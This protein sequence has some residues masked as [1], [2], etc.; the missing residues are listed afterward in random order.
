MITTPSS[1]ES[2]QLATPS[3]Q[4]RLYR[5]NSQKVVAGVCGGLGEYFSVDPVWFRIGF[6][7]LALGGGS[8]VLIY[9]LSWLIVQPQPDGYTNPPAARGQ[10][11][12]AAVIG[13][14]LMFVGTIAFVNTVAPWVG[15]YFWP[16]IFVVG[17]LALVMGGF[18]HD[19]R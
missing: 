2:E 5:S 7:V 10:I 18:N 15:Q 16:I 11:T 13:V 8:G 3:T 12:G 19:N 1:I 17:G 4:R 6:V 14:V 9:L